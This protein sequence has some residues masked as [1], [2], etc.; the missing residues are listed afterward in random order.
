MRMFEN[1]N[2]FGRRLMA[3]MEKN[4]TYRD[5]VRKADEVRED[6]K[7][8]RADNVKLRHFHAHQRALERGSKLAWAKEPAEKRPWAK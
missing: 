6:R 8:A 3:K 4:P 1:P 2:R 7:K 5:R